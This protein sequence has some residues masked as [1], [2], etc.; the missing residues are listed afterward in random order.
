MFNIEFVRGNKMKNRYLYLRLKKESSVIK[1]PNSS[2]VNYKK[3][4]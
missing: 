2:L 4:R 3:M 1:L